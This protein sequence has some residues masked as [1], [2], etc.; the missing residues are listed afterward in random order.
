M[1]ELSWLNWQAQHHSIHVHL[2]VKGLMTVASMRKRR[3]SQQACCQHKP[4]ESLQPAH[5]QITWH[6]RTNAHRQIT[7]QLLT[8]DYRTCAAK[9]PLC[10]HPWAFPR[11]S[12]V[13]CFLYPSSIVCEVLLHDLGCACTRD[14]DYFWSSLAWPIKYRQAHTSRTCI[15]RRSLF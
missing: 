4:P 11:S 12:V 6:L 1:C 13:Q 5:R 14:A 7:W 9:Q 8:N 2:W 10:D 3:V 15:C